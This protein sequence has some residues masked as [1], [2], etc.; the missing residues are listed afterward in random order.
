MFAKLTNI[1]EQGVARIREDPR[2]PVSL[3]LLF[4]DTWKKGRL[5]ETISRLIS[6]YRGLKVERIDESSMILRLYR[7]S[8]ATALV[9]SVKQYIEGFLLEDTD[10]VLVVTAGK[11]YERM[12]LSNILSK[13]G[14][15]RGWVS[16]QFIKS[17]DETMKRHK[18]LFE[19]ISLVYELRMY[20]GRIFTAAGTAN[21]W[22]K[23]VASIK[24]AL[25]EYL[26]PIEKVRGY[27]I[28]IKSLRLRVLR[29]NRIGTYIID[30]QGR[31]VLGP[32]SDV[33]VILPLLPEIINNILENYVKYRLQYSVR[34]DK[35]A[36]YVAYYLERANSIYLDAVEPGPEFFNTV[37][38]LIGKPRVWNNRLLILPIEIGNPRLVSR[39]IDKQTGMALT[40]IATYNG[41]RLLPAPG[42]TRIDA[43]MID[44]VLEMFR[45]LISE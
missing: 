44:H 15:R 16:Q 39:I 24:E 35:G 42:S 37:K 45:S 11:I 22:P 28:F 30:R 4:W 38:L 32:R 10:I 25:E 6:R 23:G 12:T 43:E 21:F 3:Q 29:K 9:V 40:L 7:E 19:I 36:K 1:A 31:V 41:I 13:L 27:Y 17:L 14:M 33:D 5:E 2:L 34:V 8:P 18:M 20:R 26:L